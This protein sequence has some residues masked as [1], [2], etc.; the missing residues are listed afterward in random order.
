MPRKTELR[1]SRSWRDL[2]SFMSKKMFT[3]EP[4]TPDVPIHRTASLNRGHGKKIARKTRMFHDYE[5]LHHENAVPWEYQAPLQRRM[6]TS[7]NASNKKPSP[8]SRH[9]PRA[10]QLPGFA[11]SPKQPTTKPP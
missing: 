4:G 2:S 6:S 11:F 7:R 1:R 8:T 3:P 10:S 5:V 9:Q